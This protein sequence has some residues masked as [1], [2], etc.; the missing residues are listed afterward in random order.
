M[1]AGVGVVL[2]LIG[3]GLPRLARAVIPSE[4]ARAFERGED[5]AADS[6]SED[7]VPHSRRV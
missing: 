3:I 7:E 1:T 5:A 6:L 4:A 2:M